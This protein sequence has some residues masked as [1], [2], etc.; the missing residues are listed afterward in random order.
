MTT[1]KICGFKDVETVKAVLHLPI[2]YIG[3]IL[4]PSK[5]QVTPALAGDMVRAVNER[6]RTGAPAPLTAGVFVNPTE[7]QLA[8]A[9]REAP[10][11]IIQLHGAESPEFCRWVREMFGVRVYRVCSFA[12]TEGAASGQDGAQAVAAAL[13][14]YAGC[15][16]G[17][18]LDT[19][20]GG[21]GKTFDWSR[22]PDYAAWARRNG[23]PMLVA[24][25]LD[26]D[27]VAELIGAYAPDGVD[28]SSGV[29][30]DGVKD[31]HK[32]TA[33]VE[34]VKRHESHANA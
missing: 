17:L 14:P 22:I 7:Q 8:E 28:V 32:I 31:V 18:L 2:D 10:L 15:V 6:R 3:F 11:D 30:M 12:E 13:D 20:G 1:V 5:R 19:V 33:F 24:G 4:A 25:G 23:I 34:R 26:P 21:T 9:L 16:D 27:N 29:E